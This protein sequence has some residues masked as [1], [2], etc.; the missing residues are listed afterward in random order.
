M[1]RFLIRLNKAIIRKFMK[2]LI[3]VCGPAGIGKSTWSK[4]YAATHPE[5][6]VAVVAADDVRKDMYGGYDKFPPDGKMMHVYKE[7][8][9]RAHALAKE[10]ESIS[11][12]LDT[13][14]LYDER[15]LFF[16]RAL[17]EF[18]FYSLTL[19]KLHDYNACLIRNKQRRKDK[20]VPENVI[21]DMASHY[22]DPS[23]ECAGKF[24]EVKEEYVD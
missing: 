4:N 18:D 24:N 21:L 3:L 6:K 7:M 8:V 10:N 22:C 14:M 23:M 20:W 9:N 17:K 5:E 11:V 13:T 1:T 16:V 2:K 12:I 15:R 19:L